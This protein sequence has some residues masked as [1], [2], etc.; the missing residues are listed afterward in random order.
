MGLY[1]RIPVSRIS[2]PV[3]QNQAV[4]ASYN[5]VIYHV[6]SLDIILSRERITKVLIRDCMHAQVVQRLCCLHATLNKSDFIVS[7][8]LNLFVL[9]V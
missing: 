8:L 2:N 5:I 9:L 7:M 6:T 1:A 4:S 3:R